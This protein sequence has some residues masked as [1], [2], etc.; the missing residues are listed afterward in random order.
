[1]S[2]L[3]GFVFVNRWISTKASSLIPPIITLPI[4][5]NR[6]RMRR[7]GNITA[8]LRRIL[9][10]NTRSVD[11]NVITHLVHRAASCVG[12]VGLGQ[13]G[14]VLFHPFLGRFRIQIPNVA[15]HGFFHP[16]LLR[17]AQI[18]HLYTL[19]FQRKLSVLIGA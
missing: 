13:F 5:P 19:F 12:Y 15:L 10:P 11:A 2:F 3:R 9:N 6:M 1:M 7:T 18:P 17:T 14:R 16:F 8:R 4:T